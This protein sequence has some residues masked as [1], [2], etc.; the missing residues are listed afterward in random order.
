MY[1]HTLYKIYVRQYHHTICLSF[2]NPEDLMGNFPSAASTTVNLLSQIEFDKREI[3][4]NK[5]GV[6]SLG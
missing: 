2:F 6:G 4:K 5:D 1:V 3:R